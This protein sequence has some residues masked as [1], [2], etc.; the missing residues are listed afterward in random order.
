ML[1][2]NE[3]TTGAVLLIFVNFG[4]VA[5]I[6]GRWGTARAAHAQFYHRT[7]D[8]HLRV[9]SMNEQTFWISREVNVTYKRSDPSRV[10]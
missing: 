4:R 1:G 8:D 5:K 2:C 3:A 6:P 7:E 10:K 9:Q